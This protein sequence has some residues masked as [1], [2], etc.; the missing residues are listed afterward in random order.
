[1]SATIASTIRALRLQHGMTQDDLAEKLHVTRQA[2]SNY[3][4]GK[5][6]PDTEQLTQIADVFHIPIED[7]IYGHIGSFDRKKRLTAS[8][9]IL[10]CL[11]ICL[12][13]TVPLAFRTRE[14]SIR[15]GNLSWFW[16]FT[17]GILVPLLITVIAWC[18][19]LIVLL[20]S[21]ARLRLPR[22]FKAVKW[23]LWVFLIVFLLANMHQV[24]MTAMENGFVPQWLYVLSMNAYLIS[25][26]HAAFLYPL[27][28]FIG[29]LS[30]A[31]QYSEW[32]K[33]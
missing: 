3:E 4:R 17:I 22:V 21:T 18:I 6:Y 11:L 30:G 12:A 29:M 7:L 28:F 15:L 32:S 26:R 31:D 16:F 2:V 24:L 9:I 33:R 27:L 5:T 23:I 19:T 1:M 10:F 13:V 8:I 20:L 14:E 25:Y